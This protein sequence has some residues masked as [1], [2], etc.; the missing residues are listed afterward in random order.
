ME[1]DPASI[2]LVDD[3]PANLRLLAQ[4][5]S[6]NGYTIRAVTSGARALASAELTPP[7]LVL[8][9]IRMPEMDG[10]AVCRQLKENPQTADIPVLFISAL[11]D[12]Q[13]KVTAF[14]CGGVDYI[15]K[16]FQFEEVIA[17]VKTH[18]DLRMLQ[19]N[20]ERINQR[21]ERELALAARM[22]TSL[23][24]HQMPNLPGW[25]FAASLLP[26]RMTSG[27]YFDFLNLT[28]GKMGIVV[29]DVV[30]KGVAASLLMAMT[31][32]VLRTYAAEQPEHPAAVLASANERILDYSALDQFVTIFLC[33]L[34]L[35][36]G[37]LIY[38]NAGHSSGI[39]H[40]A[41]AGVD[42][43]YLK[44]SGPPV[45]V[46][47]DVQWE[48]KVVSLEPGDVL[49]LYT[50]GIFEA[51]SPE[52]EFYGSDRLQDILETH[53]YQTAQELHDLILLD[54]QQF[55]GQISQEDD[56]TLVV[57]KRELLPTG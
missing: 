4:L 5:L 23:M 37:E 22:Q 48:E 18:L 51:E 40:R 42:V 8:L 2:L 27:D 21:M 31:S 44:N 45:G 56:V 11:D 35:A 3:N 55:T 54:V 10:Y 29:A 19:Q 20:L 17:R 12:I 46:I 38:T 39:L 57:V 52:G 47:E 26:A 7:D 50:D 24:P 33:V 53:P 13:D 41:R 9:D 30:D 25:Q 16:P 34:D 6:E 43:V 1:T 49:A 32:I 15:T 36:S 14:G 28:N